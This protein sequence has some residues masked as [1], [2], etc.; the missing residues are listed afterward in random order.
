MLIDLFETLVKLFQ[1]LVNPF[2]TLVNP[3]ETL[4]NLFETL[5]NLFETLVNLFET[6]VDLSESCFHARGEFLQPC[7]NDRRE[8]VHFHEP[9]GT[10]VKVASQNF[11]L[12]WNQISFRYFG[13][14]ASISPSPRK[15]RPI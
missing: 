2:E 11:Y 6:L 10:S 14:S 7:L 1:T 5:V 13:S 15:F 8:F 4:V 9:E 3:F 12:V